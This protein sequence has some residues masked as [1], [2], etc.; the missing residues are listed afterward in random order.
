MEYKSYKNR[1][2]NRNNCVFGLS[3]KIILISSVGGLRALNIFYLIFTNNMLN[4]LAYSI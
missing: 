2:Y 4:L 1:Y 3:E